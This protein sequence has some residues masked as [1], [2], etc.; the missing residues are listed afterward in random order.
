MINI[1]LGNAGLH[2][3]VVAR[4]M[5]SAFQKFL[6]T[7]PQYLKRIEVV[8][9]DQKRLLVFQREIANR[10]P[11]FVLNAPSRNDLRLAQPL[12]KPRVSRTAQSWNEFY[13][14]ISPKPKV[15]EDGDLFASYV[16]EIDESV[17]KKSATAIE[18]FDQPSPSSI[19]PIQRSA[20]SV[21]TV[22]IDLCSDKDRNIDEVRKF[23]LIVSTIKD[24]A[25]NAI[26]C[27]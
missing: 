20:T 7:K 25:I 4:S 26:N 23:A 8:I 27:N 6:A 22:T 13:P 18:T 12:P 17:S 3:T 5:T 1:V 16:A 2:S 10:C 24:Y 14:K 11:N 9:Y 21:C 15:V 19:I